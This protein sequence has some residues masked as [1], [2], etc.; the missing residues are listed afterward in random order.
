[1]TLFAQFICSILIPFA[2]LPLLGRL[3]LLPYLIISYRLAQT[4]PLFSFS[5]AP[6]FLLS[7]LIS[8]FALFKLLFGFISE[9]HEYRSFLGENFSGQKFSNAYDCYLLP[10]NQ[11]P[12][13]CPNK[14]Q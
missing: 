2:P 4:L 8:L 11:Q 9:A 14:L 6:Q 13:F 3:A 1:M 7:F 12:S 5:R 10:K